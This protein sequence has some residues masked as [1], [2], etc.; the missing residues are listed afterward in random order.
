MKE[1]SRK[2]LNNRVGRRS[3]PMAGPAYFHSRTTDLPPALQERHSG[4]NLSPKYPQRSPLGGCGQ[5]KARAEFN[6]IVGE[7]S[8]LKTALDLL[9]I[10]A[11]TDSTVLIL[12]ETGTGKELVARAA[13]TLSGRSQ[14]P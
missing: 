1:P 7:S 4:V 2:D 9:S 6:E 13:H 10:V 3:D 5:L 11:P 14:R 8:A 12:G